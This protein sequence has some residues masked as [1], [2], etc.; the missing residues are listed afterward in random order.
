MHLNVNS[1]GEREH[2]RVQGGRPQG[3]G[4]EGGA[5][6]GAV[7]GAAPPAPGRSYCAVY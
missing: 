3:R 7:G 6:G 4:G 2:A 1:I 5:G